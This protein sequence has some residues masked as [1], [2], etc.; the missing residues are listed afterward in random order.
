MHL[1]KSIVQNIFWRG[2][3]FLS[4]FVLNILISRHFKAVDSGRIYYLINN[5][6]L[7]LLI[8][9]ASVESG[10]TYYSSKNEISKGRIT[11]FCYLWAVL[12]T[13]ICAAAI[14]IFP[15]FFLGTPGFNQ[16]HFIAGIVYVS[17]FL[18]INYFS[19]LFFVRQ[20]YFS[21]NFIQLLI[22]LIMISIVELFANKPMMRSHFILIFF[23]SFL[24]QGI[25][26]SMVYFFTQ[27]SVR[28]DIPDL[29]EIKRITK[30]SFMALTSNLIFF[31]VYRVDYWFVKKFCSDH[32]LGNY[33]QVSKLGQIFL[34]IPTMLAAIIFPKTASGNDSDMHRVLRIL[35]RVLFSV[36][37]VIILCVALLGKWVFPL[38]YGSTFDAMYQPFLLLSPGIL[39]LSIQVLLA[40][41]FA[42]EN[43]L[44][45]NLIGSVIALVIIISGDFLLIPFFGINA[46]AAVS[47]AGYLCYMAYSLLIFRN[48][49]PSELSD[50]F[51]LKQ[52]D[53]LYVSRILSIRN[54]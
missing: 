7:L 32:D 13:I 15:V 31:L 44:S 10:A 42:G 40:A 27:R 3:Y 9:G 53:L 17:G 23:S 46:A 48:Q 39:S 2:L 19:A 51:L 5:L 37:F 22:C 28:I 35:S 12:A 29:S 4:V 38:L 1:K 20:D 6:S 25:V 52:S 49:N 33:I 54:Q 11:G 18:L 26:V 30:Y 21:S 24:V 41:Y 36:Y 16:E 45:V 43:K 50:F 47:S 8:A 14:L 34:L